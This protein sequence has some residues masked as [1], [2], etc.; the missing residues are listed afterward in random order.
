MKL[1]LFML[2]FLP[3]AHASDFCEMVLPPEVGTLTNS[4]YFD[5]TSSYY[6][7]FQGTNFEDLQVLKNCLDYSVCGKNQESLVDDPTNY[8]M[9]IWT[10]LTVT[11]LR[12]LVSSCPIENLNTKLIVKEN[13][14]TGEVVSLKDMNPSASGQ[15]KLLEKSSPAF[16]HKPSDRVAKETMKKLD[17]LL[18]ESKVKEAEDLVLYIWGIKLHDYKLAYGGVGDNYA[19]TEHGKKLVR[20]GKTWLKD[21]CSFTRMIRHEAEHIAQFKRMKECKSNHNLSDHVMRERAT[22]MN[23]ARFVKEIC[24]DSNIKDFCLDKLKSDYLRTK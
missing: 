22:Y 17:L 8:R 2:F 13:N 21:S 12:N 16:F 15:K 1:L 23:D 5:F 6:L 14:Q 9:H 18:K 20:Y 3:T 11:Q 4:N 19:T 24:P 10:K 7:F